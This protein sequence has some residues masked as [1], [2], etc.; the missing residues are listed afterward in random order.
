V[1]HRAREQRRLT[2]EAD[3]VMVAGSIQIS[4]ATHELIRDVYVWARRGMV[5]AEGNGEMETY[6]LLARR[7]GQTGAARADAPEA[8]EEPAGRTA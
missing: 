3:L 4:A 1:R 5:D 2:L 8:G 6:F 7:D